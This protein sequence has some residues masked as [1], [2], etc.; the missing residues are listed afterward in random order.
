[1]PDDQQDRRGAL[2][3][4]RRLEENLFEPLLPETRAEFEAGGGNELR[5]KM[6]AVHST[7]ALVVNVFQYWRKRNPAVIAEACGL[8]SMGIIDLRFE[9]KFPILKCAGNPPHVD[10]CFDFDSR[11]PVRVGAVEGKFSEPWT[12]RE[13]PN[14]KEAH[15][16]DAASLWKDLPE[17]RKLADRIYR[18]SSPFEYLNAAQLI[19]HILG[20]KT[21]TGGKGNFHLLY[22]W[23]RFHNN[24]DCEKHRAEVEAFQQVADRDGIL[25]SSLTYQELISRLA[26]RCRDEHR[27]HVDYLLNRY[28]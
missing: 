1:M 24:Q 14:F 19:K 22:L 18:G 20:L 16:V 6:R 11:S 9:A 23:Y 17:L 21:Q 10:C 25:F 26:H 28:C 3:Y 5:S 15:F 27:R 13:P 4:T 2:A 7:A 12:E 8:P